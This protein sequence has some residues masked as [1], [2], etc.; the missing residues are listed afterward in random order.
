MSGDKTK[1]P[2]VNAESLNAAPAREYNPGPLSH[3]SLLD[4]HN[5]LKKKANQLKESER[6][7]LA[8]E[9]E[10]ILA[11]VVEHKA[12]LS[13]TELAKGIQ[14]VDPIKTSWRVPSC[15]QNLPQSRHDE[16][17]ELTGISVDGE[18]IPPPISSF[19]DMKF[20]KSIIHALKE[21][22]ISKPTPI[23]MQGL[24]ALL[25]GRDLIGIAYTGSGKTLAFSLPLLMFCLE[26]ETAL[27]FVREEGPFGLI[28]CPSVNRD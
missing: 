12:L 15:I 27:P 9:E 16:V 19:K 10:K 2:T 28:I 8:K 4:Q 7:K 6:E 26:Q 18:D 5:E 21:K 17:R 23:Q 11:S 22:G 25:M 14:Y 13:F 1:A 20:P 24:P 3:L